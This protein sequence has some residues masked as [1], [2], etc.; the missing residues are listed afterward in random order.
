METFVN[1]LMY[2]MI[3]MAG[4]SFIAFAIIAIVSMVFWSYLIY[5]DAFGSAE[6]PVEEVRKEPIDWEQEF[7]NLHQDIKKM[8]K[9]HG[10]YNK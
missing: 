4:I 2:G 3:G 9:E 6:E 1:I 8:S 5:K 7:E 10:I